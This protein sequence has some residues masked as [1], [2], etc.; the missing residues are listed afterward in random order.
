MRLLIAARRQP[1]LARRLAPMRELGRHWTDTLV[2]KPRPETSGPARLAGMAL[3][4]AL[5]SLRSGIGY[6]AIGGETPLEHILPEAI[7]RSPMGIDRIGERLRRPLASWPG[8]VCIGEDDGTAILDHIRRLRPD[9]ILVAG[10]LDC[11]HGWGAEAPL[12][13]LEGLTGYF[14]EPKAYYPVREAVYLG[15]DTEMRAA[16][17]FS[18]QAEGEAEIIQL[19]APRK[20]GESLARV[21]VILGEEASHLLVKAAQAVLQSRQRP[22]SHESVRVRRPSASPQDAAQ[23]AD[24]VIR[25]RR[26]L[27]R[28]K[29]P[30]LQ[31]LIEEETPN[32]NL[33]APLA[34]FPGGVYIFLYHSIYDDDGKS[35]ANIYRKA[36]ISASRFAAHLEFLARHFTPL[37]LSRAPEVFRQGPPDRPYA[38]VSFDD[39][40]ANILGEPQRRLRQLGFSP[41]LFVNRDFAEGETYYRVLAAL[42]GKAGKARP[43]AHRLH[44]A[45][46][47]VPWSDDADELFAQTK[48]HYREAVQD[49]VSRC[50]REEIGSPDALKVH[51]T[52]GDICELASGGW[53]IGNHTTRHQTLSKLDPNRLA[54]VLD[55]NWAWL[56]SLAIP[57]LPWIGF[58][59][60]LARHVNDAVRQHLDRRPGHYGIFAGGGVNFIPSRSEWLRLAVPDH[61]VAGLHLQISKA[62]QAT[63]RALARVSR[64]RGGRGPG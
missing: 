20:V 50:Y 9:L 55:G 61:D 60:G 15:H 41:A 43:L 13:A 18:G 64:A 63:I 45:C 46:P 27:A 37:S 5:V 62:V 51:L 11:A 57:L 23:F 22:R 12:G 25:L 53:E 42:L 1:G 49:V 34:R 29:W 31:T 48:N 10:D 33:R 17:V 24:R 8:L 59:N 19:G 54:D 58:P 47:D 40:Y 44:Q 38:V 36:G 26:R 32:A 39:G 14:G 56:E 30:A 28:R 4:R 2:V 7:G 16:V 3:R 6:G 21:E 35:W 52:K